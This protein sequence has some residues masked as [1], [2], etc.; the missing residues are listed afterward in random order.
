MKLSRNVSIKFYRIPRAV[1]TKALD[2][3]FVISEI[4]F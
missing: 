2:C 4:E 3:D 1:V